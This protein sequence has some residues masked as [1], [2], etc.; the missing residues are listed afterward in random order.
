MWIEEYTPGPP[1]S[2]EEYQQHV[3]ATEEVLQKYRAHMEA[4]GEVICQ[5]W[6]IHDVDRPRSHQFCSLHVDDLV[7]K[8]FHMRYNETLPETA[9]DTYYAFARDERYRLIPAYHCRV[10]ITTYKRIMHSD[11]GLWC[12]TIPM[13]TVEAIALIPPNDLI[14]LTEGIVPAH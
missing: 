4:R 10:D 6:S 14:S 9:P 5:V 8:E 3:A 2:E 12:V 13:D 7:R 11:I 1:I